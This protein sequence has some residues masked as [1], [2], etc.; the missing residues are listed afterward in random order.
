MTGGGPDPGIDSWRN[1]TLPLLR[2]LTGQA[3]GWELKVIR[4]GA[5]PEVSVLLLGCFIIIRCLHLLQTFDGHFLHYV[6]LLFAKAE[7]NTCT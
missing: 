4:R 1:V 6:Q 2:K 3:D 5:L 7:D